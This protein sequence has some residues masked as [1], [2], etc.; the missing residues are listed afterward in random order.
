MKV[1]CKRCKFKYGSLYCSWHLIINH[2][3]ECIEEINN[4]DKNKDGNCIQYK[5]DF[6]ERL[7]RVFK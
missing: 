2:Y 4:R 5:P 6:I 3:T 7:K 1:K